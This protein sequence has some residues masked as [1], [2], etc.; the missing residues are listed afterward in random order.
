MLSP[1]QIQQRLEDAQLAG[2]LYQHT[3]DLFVLQ[4]PLEEDGS[5]LNVFVQHEQSADQ[6]GLQFGL[7][8]SDAGLEFLIAVTHSNQ[9]RS[10]EIGAGHLKGD[11]KAF[12]LLYA[13][14][15]YPKALYVVH[16]PLMANTAQ[17]KQALE[18]QLLT[19][20]NL[21]FLNTATKINPMG[22]TVY[23]MKDFIL[24]QSLALKV[25]LQICLHSS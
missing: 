17:L 1:N 12:N 9:D 21:A 11:Q 7:K 22:Q 13:F 15:N 18:Q 4:E 6:I 5:P 19:Q 25:R 23:W 10:Y 20:P 16:L 24:Q 8:I 14:Y 3:P 2:Y